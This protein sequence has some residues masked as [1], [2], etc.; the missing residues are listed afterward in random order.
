MRI[1]ENYT[2]VRIFVP[3]YEY[4]DVKW[5]EHIQFL[6]NKR[7]AVTRCYSS[8]IFTYTRNNYSCV[9]TFI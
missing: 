8:R 5:K 2:N 7:I 6:V 3:V 9:T 1:I 4:R